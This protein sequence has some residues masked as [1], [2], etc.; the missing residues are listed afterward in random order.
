MPQLDTITENG[1]SLRRVDLKNNSNKLIPNNGDILHVFPV[2]NNY[3]DAILLSNYLRQPGFVAWSKDT[4]IRDLV[5]PSSDLLNDTDRKYVLLKRLDKKT[6]NYSFDQ[7]N[8]EKIIDDESSSENILLNKNDELLFFK[9]LEDQESEESFID[10]LKK[11]GDEQRVFSGK[12]E[13]KRNMD[14][15][16]LEQDEDDSEDDELEYMKTD[17]DLLVEEDIKY[18]S[19]LEIASQMV[20]LLEN[21][22]SPGQPTQ[23]VNILGSRYPGKYPLTNDMTIEDVINA[24]GGLVDNTYLSEVEYIEVTFKSNKEYFYDKRTLSLERSDDL[25]LEVMPGSTISFK[26]APKLTKIVSLEG[27]FIFPGDYLISKG[28]TISDLINRAGGLT[29]NAFPEGLFFTRE[30]LVEAEKKRINKAADLFQQQILLASLNSGNI[31]QSSNMIT[32][33]SFKLLEEDSLDDGAYGRLVLDLKAIINSGIGDILLE[34]GDTLR[35]PSVP[36]S[37]SVI[38]EVNGPATHVYNSGK[39]VDYY[40]NL[41]GQTNQFGDI[42]EIYVISANGSIKPKGSSGFFRENRSSLESGD[43]IVVPLK[44]DT[45]SAIQAANE[46]TTII[47]QLAVATAAVS[48]F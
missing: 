11:D 18:I 33:E 29:E 24:S 34:D 17:G 44:I 20:S 46:V 25:S 12:D 22:A 45:F 14:R 42:Q 35:I 21:Q 40:L 36:N 13:L 3:M 10:E 48:S 19:R 4:R 27:E 6:G 15:D 23:Y 28:D 39:D 41:S 30:K 32:P 47:Y 16:D 1:L 7:V 9:K 38:G 2:S 26:S 37:I 5:D 31:G 8:L 43:T